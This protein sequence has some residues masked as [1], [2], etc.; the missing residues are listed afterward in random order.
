MNSLRSACRRLAVIAVALAVPWALAAPVAAEGLLRA[1]DAGL[2]WLEDPQPR[3]GRPGGTL[4]LLTPDGQVLD[5]ELSLQERLMQDARAHLPAVRDGTTSVH[6]G[7]VAGRRGSWA[8]L[9]RLGGAWLGAVHDGGQL[10][11]LDP[12]SHHP[13][14]ASRLGLAA[15]ATLVYTLADLARPLD[16]HGDIAAAGRPG[17]GA[18]FAA[19]PA[20]VLPEMLPLTPDGET[21]RELRVTLVLDTGFQALYEAAASVAVAALNVV[22]GFYRA[23]FDTHIRLH[24]LLALADNGPLTMT[25]HTQ[26]FAAFGDY[27]RDNGIPF[28]GAAHLLS[29]RVFDG[30]VIGYA[31]VDALCLP[32]RGYGINQMTYPGAGNAVLLAH[33]LGHNFGLRHDDEVSLAIGLTSAFV[34]QHCAH[35]FIMRRSLN[36]T[37]PATGFSPCSQVWFDHMSATSAQCLV[38]V[39][40]L[41][42]DGFEAPG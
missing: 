42:A 7:Q 32:A 1:T 15:D 17:P 10:W 33:E 24:Y 19:L 36:I 6:A 26:L 11:F 38:P 39:D 13:V 23:Q 16:F 14:L 12:A 25:S 21:A 28:H 40:L 31:A 20:A 27:V 30:S 35:N 3:D 41:F 34:T 5:L 8:R 29:G 2:H 37:D 4:R 22:D 9:A 18:G